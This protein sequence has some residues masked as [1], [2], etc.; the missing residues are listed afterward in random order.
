MTPEN[1]AIHDQFDAIMRA[2]GICEETLYKYQV[3]LMAIQQEIERE[4]HKI[5]ALKERSTHFIRDNFEALIEK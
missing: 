3:Q 2:R 4:T 5:T 1:K